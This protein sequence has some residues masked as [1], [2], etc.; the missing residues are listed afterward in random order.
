MT[1]KTERQHKGFRIAWP[2]A[3]FGGM[4]LISM[5]GLI[6]NFLRHRYKEQLGS[7]RRNLA[8]AFASRTRV[9]FLILACCSTDG[10]GDHLTGFLSLSNAEGLLGMVQRFRI[11]QKSTTENSRGGMV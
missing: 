5:L 2:D 8:C 9:P 11:V 4:I 1:E 6:Y 10:H 3:L 7:L